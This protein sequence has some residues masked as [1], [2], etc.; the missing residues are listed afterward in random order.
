MEG[1]EME[2]VFGITDETLVPESESSNDRMVSLNQ[3]VR[4]RPAEDE[5]LADL[6]NPRLSSVPDR[7]PSVVKS[8]IKSMIDDSTLSRIDPRWAVRTSRSPPVRF[9][10]RPP[11]PFWLLLLKSDAD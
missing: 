2:G 6:L 1:V 10:L 8:R 9:E 11:E 4:S 5:E 3:F 7:L